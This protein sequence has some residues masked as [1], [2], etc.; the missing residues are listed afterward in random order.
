MGSS[1]FSTSCSL[2]GVQSWLPHP[3][4]LPSKLSGVSRAQGMGCELSP[5]DILP[6]GEEGRAVLPAPLYVNTRTVSVLST[7]LQK[8]IFQNINSFEPKYLIWKT[9]VGETA[10]SSREIVRLPLEITIFEQ[11]LPC[12]QLRPGLAKIQPT[13]TSEFPQEIKR[14]Y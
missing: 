12:V 2:Y 6:G 4:P 11:C 5:G 7:H 9:E 1:A 13:W 14:S 8:F 3:C 10:I